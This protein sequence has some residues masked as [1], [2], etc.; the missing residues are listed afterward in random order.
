MLEPLMLCQEQSQLFITSWRYDWN[1]VGEQK[2]NVVEH[3]IYLLRQPNSVL[4][5][6]VLGGASVIE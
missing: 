2:A 4:L 6:E 1:A 3:Q 5:I